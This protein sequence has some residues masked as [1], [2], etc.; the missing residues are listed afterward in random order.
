MKFGTNTKKATLC[1]PF[2]NMAALRVALA[3]VAMW[4][5]P[6]IAAT[7][8]NFVVFV[9]DDM[10]YGDLAC[11]GRKNVSSPNV[12]RLAAEGIRFTQWIR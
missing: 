3:L 9:V 7:Q 6:S 11:Y 5:S 8:P 10:G 4:I 12:D 1:P 2:S